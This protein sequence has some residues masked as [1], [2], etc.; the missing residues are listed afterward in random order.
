MTPRISLSLTPDQAIALRD[1]LEFYARISMGQLQVLTEKVREGFIPIRGESASP[2][3]LASPD[4]CA[5]IDDLMLQVKTVLGYPGSSSMGIGHQHV[6][7]SGHRAWEMYKVIAQ[8]L[9]FHADPQPQFRGVHYDGL[10]LR[11]TRDPAPVASVIEA[12]EAVS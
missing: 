6:H 1:A 8:T 4:A 3:V 11:Y 5:E 12:G 9:A 2:R 10:M 7:V